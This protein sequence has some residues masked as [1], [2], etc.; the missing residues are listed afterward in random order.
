[1]SRGNTIS[2]AEWNIMNQLWEQE[3]STITKLTAAL[4]E[5][6][7]WTQ[8]TVITLL[9]RLMEK[10]C[11]AYQEIGRTKHF[12]AIVQKEDIVREETESLIERAYHGSVGLLVNALVQQYDL[13]EEEIKELNAIIKKA[14]KK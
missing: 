2:N 4:K 7:G 13:S 6:T 12:Y 14:T 1:M 9:K 10:G 8:A 5:S 11:V 3:S